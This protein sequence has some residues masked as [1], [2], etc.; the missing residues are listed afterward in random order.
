[1]LTEENPSE[2]VAYIGEQLRYAQEFYLEAE[3]VWSAIQFAKSNQTAPI[4]E[5]INAGIEEWIK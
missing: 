2:D 3:V 1:M 4:Q 5:C